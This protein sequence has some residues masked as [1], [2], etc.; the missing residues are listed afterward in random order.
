[1]A[2]LVGEAHHLVLDGRAVARADAFDLAAVQRRAVQRVADDLV[3][4][5]GGVGDPAAD[6]LRMLGHVAEEGHH[7][8]RVVA[9]LLS[10]TL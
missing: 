6:L 7:R 1:V 4:A 8:Q 5:L 2:V 10:I 3:G 9:G